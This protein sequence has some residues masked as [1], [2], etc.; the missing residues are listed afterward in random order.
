MIQS[1]RAGSSARGCPAGAA[2]RHA[3]GFWA[4]LGMALLAAPAIASQACELQLFE[5][6]SGRLL[7]NF[8]LDASSA[9]AQIAFEHSVLGT[10]VIDTYLFTPTAVLIEESFEGEGYG[11]P[12]AAGP[13]ERLSREGARQRL[14]LYRP[15]EPLVIRPLPEQR[16]RLV[17]PSRQVLLGSLSP[18]AAIELQ[19]QGCPTR[20][21]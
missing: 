3:P 15:V 19:A 1:V 18:S 10:T 7:M 2:R 6:R 20:H 8:P 5:H 12:H 11:L 14:H 13:G 21:P 9:A 16:M 17:T 4:L